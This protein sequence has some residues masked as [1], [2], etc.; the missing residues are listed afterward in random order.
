MPAPTTLETD[1]DAWEVPPLS[2]AI[3]PAFPRLDYV[4]GKWVDH[5]QSEVVNPE[6]VDSDELPLS[7]DWNERCQHGTSFR[8]VC[9]D[10]EKEDEQESIPPPAEAE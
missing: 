5:V 8:Y 1:S 2:T 4:D 6:Y 3:A 9:P 10:C 7:I